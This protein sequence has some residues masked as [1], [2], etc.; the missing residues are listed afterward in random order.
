MGDAACVGA[1]DEAR[2]GAGVAA[3]ALP[4]LT[5]LAFAPVLRPVPDSGGTKRR[6]GEEGGK[7]T[8]K[9]HVLPPLPSVPAV[10]HGGNSTAL[11]AATSSQRGPLPRRVA[12]VPRRQSARLSRRR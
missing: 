5:R 7:Y 2:P 10:P 12:A 3:R 4:P 11:I 8:S 1:K 6:R 9:S